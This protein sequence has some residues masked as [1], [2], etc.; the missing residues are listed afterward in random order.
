MFIVLIGI[1]SSGGYLFSTFVDPLFEEGRKAAI[2]DM[3]SNISPS[4]FYSFY[5]Y[6]FGRVHMRFGEGLQERKWIYWV[7]INEITNDLTNHP[8]R[9]CTT[10]NDTDAAKVLFY[11]RFG[12]PSRPLRSLEDLITFLS[13]S[14]TYD[15]LA[16]FASFNH[17]MDVNQDQ[18]AGLDSWMTD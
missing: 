5:P 15:Q 12:A 11:N 10:E 3:N 9:V 7:G 13:G 16:D 2:E 18:Q 4:L 14:S 8:F 6:F 1:A 17:A